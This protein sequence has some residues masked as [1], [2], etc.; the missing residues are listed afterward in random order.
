[1]L[2]EKQ[3]DQITKKKQ[4]WTVI[5]FTNIIKRLLYSYSKT[6]EKLNDIE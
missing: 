1:M 5:F 6:K 3:Y 2:S 4:W